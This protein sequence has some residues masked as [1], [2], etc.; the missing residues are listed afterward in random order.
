MGAGFCPFFRMGAIAPLLYQIHYSMTSI[1][2]QIIAW[3]THD[4]SFEAGAEI[5]RVNSKHQG[6]IRKFAMQGDTK[7][8]CEMLHYHLSKLAGVDEASWRRLLR[9]PVVPVDTTDYTNTQVRFELLAAVPEDVRKVFRLRDEFPFLNARECP[10]ELKILVADLL[11][12]HDRYVSD[13]QK[14]FSATTPEEIATL[15]ASVVENYLENRQIWDEL[16][17]YK[18]EGKPLGEHPVWQRAARL[19]ELQQMSNTDLVKLNKNIPTNISRITKKLEEDPQN[20][21]TTNRQLALENYKW[22]LEEV[23]KLLK[24]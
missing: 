5:F 23:K 14:L 11:S 10:N 3:V 15:S 1:K 2:E 13:H 24:L 20:K 16:N 19:K 12:T 17:H 9:N 7:E 21:E 18:T 8:N 6:L 22:E 4:R